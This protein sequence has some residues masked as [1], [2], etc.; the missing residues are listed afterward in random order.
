[1]AFDNKVPMAT[2]MDKSVAAVTS[3]PLKSHPAVHS[4]QMRR[5]Y[6]VPQ[7]GNDVVQ[8]VM[9]KTGTETNPDGI[10]N[11]DVPEMEIVNALY[12]KFLA[13]SK[14]D[15][16]ATPRIE[17]KSNESRTNWSEQNELGA[18]L[19]LGATPLNNF[20]NLVM[21]FKKNRDLGA[22]NIK[23]SDGSGF[24]SAIYNQYGK[25]NTN[26]G[27]TDVMVYKHP[28]MGETEGKAGS[29]KGVSYEL[30]AIKFAEIVKATKWGDAKIA[31]SILQFYQDGKIPEIIEEKDQRRNFGYLVTLMTVP[32]SVRSV[33]TFPFGLLMLENIK[34]GMA[35]AAQAFRPAEGMKEI[36]KERK[37]IRVA[38]KKIRDELKR[39]EE[40]EGGKKKAKKVIEVEE[41]DDDE[42]N[43]EV[44]GLE[45][46][47]PVEPVYKD[48]IDSGGLYA[49]A[50]S[51][52]K[53]PLN[54][55]ETEA[56]TGDLAL[57][58]NS[59]NKNSYYWNVTLGRFEQMLKVYLATHPEQLLIDE[60]KDDKQ[61]A[62]DG[63]INHILMYFGVGQEITGTSTPN[64]EIKRESNQILSSLFN[65]IKPSNEG[66]KF[67]SPFLLPEGGNLTKSLFEFGSERKEE[68][69]SFT[70][71]LYQTHKNTYEQFGQSFQQYPT[72][73][74]SPTNN[75]SGYEQQL[76]EDILNRR[77]ER[78]QNPEEFDLFGNDVEQRLEE[79]KTRQ[80]TF[81]ITRSV[82]S[83]LRES[84]LKRK[85]GERDKKS[86]DVNEELEGT[87]E[88][89]EEPNKRRK[90]PTQLAIKKMTLINK[91]RGAI[92]NIM[93]VN[94]QEGYPQ[95]LVERAL[96]ANLDLQQFVTNELLADTDLSLEE[97][98]LRTIITQEV[99]QYY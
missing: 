7:A 75:Y 46:I 81:Q 80:T 16:P 29:D 40:R 76:T 58:D 39:K 10:N 26:T 68:E 35:T 84:R 71:S 83:D 72:A 5:V 42:V 67:T 3:F 21:D 65:I 61:A 96:M 82:S 57:R 33:G 49:P 97:E 91:I 24:S 93:S 31:E 64:R 44:P 38:N 6:N 89:K 90:V 43:D 53:K 1:M 11:Y 48:E 66:G 19:V 14:Q 20:W 54:D 85:V 28:E 36:I 15:Y 23:S 13:F 77:D 99:A 41:V 34:N 87:E 86:E 88:K 94:W 79:L 47:V 62:T 56:E 69:Y 51:G 50:Y 95:D 37:K 59:D 52:S 25:T 17:S 8:R 92:L 78:K 74:S 73:P 2:N 30:A 27:N 63:V 60:V 70:K 22:V 18:E 12:Q 4:F 98:E 9:I 45:G 55:L 32:E